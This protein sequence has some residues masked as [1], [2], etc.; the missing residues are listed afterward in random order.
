MVIYVICCVPILI[1]INGIRVV[2][3]FSFFLCMSPTRWGYKDL[4]LKLV[5]PLQD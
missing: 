4:G 5:E 1:Q 3:S 2:Y